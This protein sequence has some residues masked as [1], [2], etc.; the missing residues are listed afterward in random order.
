M[1]QAIRRTQEW[2]L[3]RQS[4]EG[5][6]V[7]ELT[8]DA[9]V[10][11]GYVPIMY[12]MTGQVGEDRR[13]KVVNYVR[14]KQRGDGSWSAYEGGPGDLN[15][16][17]QTYFALKLAG[18]PAEEPYMERA[19]DF[20]RN[21]GGIEAAN[22]FTKI[23]LAIFGQYDWRRIPTVPPEVILLP[24]WFS[25]N[26]YEFASWSRATIVAL[27]MVFAQKPV[28]GVPDFATIRELYIDPEARRQSVPARIGSLFGW[29]NLFVAMDRIFKIWERVPFKPGRGLALRRV[30]R[31]IQ[32]HQ[33]GDGSWGGIMLPWLYSLIALKCAGYPL[34]H[35]TVE[36]G[37]KGLERYIVEDES[38]LRL[39]PA[40][41][42]V[43][44]TAWVLVA[45]RDSGLPTDHATLVRAARWLLEEEIRISGDWR[46]KN[47]SVQPTGWAF[48]FENDLYPDI[49]DT[50]VVPRALLKVRLPQREETRKVE[51]L[52]RAV[53][54][55]VAMQSRD[56]GWA[57]FDRD[58]NKEVLARIPFADF[59]T[60]LDPT[61]PDVTAHAIELLAELE[62][63]QAAVKKAVAYLK[64]RQEADGAWF[65]RWGVNYIYGTGLVLSALAAAGEDM[66]QGY[67]RKVVTWLESRQND[68]GGWGETCHTYEEPHLRGQGP[69]T[70]SQTA[71]ALMGLIV[72][73]GSWTP[74]VQKGVDFLLRTQQ[75]DGSWQENAF[76]GTGFPR[77][78][79]LRYDLY[80]IYF[81]LMAL[82]QYRRRVREGAT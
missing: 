3:A 48:E 34:D 47:R 20:A 57:A 69:S 27:M 19:R 15:V 11:A 10:T 80:R 4:G 38:T 8:A 42:P 56:G 59:M 71:W 73:V 2:L 61:S 14:E 67:V 46:V 66:E 9:S 6:W 33:E 21:L 68:D 60:P 64:S 55:I 53:Q 70:A 24:E 72:A 54:W 63:E 7:G 52:S 26:I 13:R 35:P 74:A 16:T 44:D 30:E 77:A 58:N 50:A 49:D 12:F 22:V 18:V 5:Y 39:Q 75:E 78:F 81:P 79:Y 43:W 76:T 31:W 28:C 36:R 62:V 25:L 37:M 1:E 32:E 29:G 82:A 17:V 41:S 51:A 40:T 65:G 45:L 23:W